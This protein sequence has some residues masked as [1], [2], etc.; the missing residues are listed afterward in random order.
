MYPVSIYFYVTQ[1]WELTFS[2]H[3]SWSEDV[4]TGKIKPMFC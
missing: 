1:E 3:M 2:T 4:G